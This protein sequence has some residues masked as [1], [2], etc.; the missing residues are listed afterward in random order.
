MKENFQDLKKEEIQVFKWRSRKNCRSVGRWGKPKYPPIQL[1]RNIHWVTNSV[2]NHVSFPQ[3]PTEVMWNVGLEE[4][5]PIMKNGKRGNIAMPSP[6]PSQWQCG[7]RRATVG[8]DQV[9]HL[10]HGVPMMHTGFQKIG[11][12]S[13]NPGHGVPLNSGHGAPIIQQQMRVHLGHGDPQQKLALPPSSG[14][15]ELSLV[16]RL[17]L[18]EEKQ[19]GVPLFQ[20]L[21]QALPWW[22]KNAPTEIVDL[23]V[24]G[25]QPG[26]AQPPNLSS[27][28]IK[29]SKEEICKVREV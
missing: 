4:M 28:P 9:P 19:V 15:K 7:Q 29:K 8:M 26:W 14:V 6:Q 16:D 21:R 5:E 1:Q 18:L 20:R 12:G 24:H 23:I 13:Q 22:K 25:V 3:V 2:K 10:G 17:S 11:Y 27:I